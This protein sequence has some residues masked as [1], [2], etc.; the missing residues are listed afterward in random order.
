MPGSARGVGS[1]CTVP[2][3]L[4]DDLPDPDDLPPPPPPPDPDDLP[5]PKEPEDLPLPKDPEDLPLLMLCLP[6]DPELI[7]PAE[8]ENRLE[9]EE[10]SVREG[11]PDQL[12]ADFR[13]DELPLLKEV[14]EVP[15]SLCTE[16]DRWVFLL[17]LKEKFPEF[18]LVLVMV[19]DFPTFEEFLLKTWL[20]FL[21]LDIVLF[22]L[23]MVFSL[24]T[25]VLLFR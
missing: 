20:L 3:Y 12:R 6:D 25:D 17:S 1:V 2:F 21:C 22:I 14:P 15:L 18:L 7:L 19:A 10:T 24:L 11:L 16:Y 9:E 5:L 13:D 23:F 8:A 4:L